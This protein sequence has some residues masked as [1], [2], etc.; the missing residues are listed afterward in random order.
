[1]EC[2]LLLGVRRFHLSFGHEFSLW[3]YLVIS[4]LASPLPIPLSRLKIYN[5]DQRQHFAI[6][7]DDLRSLLFLCIW[8][9]TA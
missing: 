8:A 1:M 6:T 7:T 5:R 4:V 9:V 2:L 3:C